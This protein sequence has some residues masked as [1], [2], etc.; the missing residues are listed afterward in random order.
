MQKTSNSF[1]LLVAMGAALMPIWGVISQRL[2]P[3][4]PYCFSSRMASARVMLWM[5]RVSLSSVL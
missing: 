2:M 5:L 4:M 3:Q 1:S